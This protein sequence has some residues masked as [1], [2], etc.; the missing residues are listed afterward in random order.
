MSV[1]PSGPVDQLFCFPCTTPYHAS[2]QNATLDSMTTV[3]YL[4]AM[5]TLEWMTRATCGSGKYDRDLWFP[6]IDGAGKSFTA[7]NICNTECPVRDI[8]REYAITF[9]VALTGTWGGLSRYEI[10]R[11]RV[12]RGLHVDSEAY[13]WGLPNG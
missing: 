9:P 13:A 3:V 8:C 5:K 4:R 7:K 10:R 12:I 6:G 1:L 11:Q 2:A